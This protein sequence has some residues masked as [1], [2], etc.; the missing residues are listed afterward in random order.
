MTANLFSE[1]S[2]Y[3]NHIATGQTGYA[4]KINSRK[5]RPKPR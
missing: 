1:D 2:Q 3:H 5:Q 4:E